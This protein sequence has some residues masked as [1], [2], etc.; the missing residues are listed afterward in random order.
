VISLDE[1]FVYPADTVENPCPF[2]VTYHNQGTFV[3]STHYDSAGAVIRQFARGSDFLGSYSANGRQLS[4]RSPAIHLDA[5]TNTL[6]GT[7]NQRHFV[8]PGG[9]VVC[10]Q[11]G[12]FV[13]DVATGNVVSVPGLDVPQTAEFCA[14][15]A[16]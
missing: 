3:I 10:A 15:L 12:R 14:A 7:G 9:G 16:P 4:W 1:T 13:I 8:V 5:A 6:V 2:E 11:P